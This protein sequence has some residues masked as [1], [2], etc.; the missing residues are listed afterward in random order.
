MRLFSLFLASF[1]TISV[2]Y[3][4]KS[5]D[6][7]KVGKPDASLF[8]MKKYEKDSSAPAVV[9]H[10]EFLVYYKISST[11]EMWKHTTVNRR[12]K[13]LTSEGADYADVAISLYHPGSHRTMLDD[14]EACSVNMENGKMVKSPVKKN[15]IFRE[16][17]DED[18][19]IVK[20][21]IPNV[22]EGSII[23]YSYSTKSSTLIRIPTHVFQC[24]I[25]VAYS[26]AVYE[27]PDFLI[28]NVDLVNTLN[29]AISQHEDSE[30]YQVG[31]SSIT[32][33]E[34]VI[35]A[36]AR[37]IPAAKKEPFL[38]N[39]RNH[40]NKISFELYA[41]QFPGDFYT[42]V[43]ATWESVNNTLKDTK[44]SDYVKMSNPLK[45]ETIAALEGADTDFKKIRAILKL[46][47][48]K[49]EWDGYYNL[50][51]QSP[52]AALSK[53]S[54]CSADIN[55]LLNAMLNDA[56]FQT[57]LVMLNPRFLPRMYK[58]TLD[59]INHFVIQ[60]QLSTGRVCY[61]D[62]TNEYSDINVLPAE[63][64]V[65]ASHIYGD[66]SN[67]LIDL[68]KLT[69]SSI[70]K[71]LNGKIT[72]DGELKLNVE[73][74]YTNMEALEMNEEIAKYN[75]EDE[76][77]DKLESS[78]KSEVSDF[79][80]EQSNPLVR[81]K[82]SYTKTPD[83]TDGYIYLNSCIIN[84]LSENPFTAT[85]RQFPIEFRYP[86]GKSIIFEIEIPEGY[87]VEGLPIN[88]FIAGGKG[89]L[90]A[91]L[92]VECKGNIISGRFDYALD[93]L[94]YGINEYEDIKAFHDK[95]IQIT[96]QQIV[97]KRK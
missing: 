53:G 35:E 88:H 91:T 84:V 82:Y 44:F 93:R 52:K 56:G 17:A 65:D 20:F 96:T 77:L 63:L 95:L 2:C 36:E 19:T 47:H 79:T 76:M 9:L 8:E 27:L 24:E 66:N 40:L 46:L 10:D 31:R 54:G 71:I 25:P 72:E 15:L 43:S 26:R 74:T 58:P 30:V 34:K 7:F 32:V 70:A 14:I 67:N 6:N 49:I 69:K 37:D 51:S 4:Q 42:K 3:A 80:L 12:I 73:E 18:E 45:A 13:V 23:D 89:N 68:S 48:S 86:T 22:K 87:T 16:R 94:L 78:L 50:I 64:L 90:R 92:K 85:K 60:V 75:N 38:W 39:Y 21:T 28:F 83:A 55:F 97:I 62:G 33:H 1:L 59:H 11:G 57:K 29:I 61:V 41:H 5:E 81:R